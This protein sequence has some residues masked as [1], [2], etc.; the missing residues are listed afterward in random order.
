MRYS[1]KLLGTG[2]QMSKTILIVSPTYSDGQG[3]IER[4]VAGHIH[5]LSKHKRYTIFVV[6]F[7]GVFRI[8]DGAK[9]IVKRYQRRN[10]YNAVLK[11]SRVGAIVIVHDPHLIKVFFPIWLVTFF[12]RGRHLSLFTH[13]LFFHSSNYQRLKKMA[14]VVIK[15]VSLLADSVFVAGFA[16]YDALKSLGHKRLRLLGNGFDDFPYHGRIKP[17]SEKLRFVV[18]G[19][20]SPNKNLSH[21]ITVFTDRL[22]PIFDYCELI[23]VA[24]SLRQETRDLVSACRDTVVIEAA[25]DAEVSILLASSD[26]L[27]SASSFEGFGRTVVEAGLRGTIPF[28]NKNAGHEFIATK[29]RNMFLVDWREEADLSE[30]ITQLVAVLRSDMY[31]GFCSDLR[32]QCECF[33]WPNIAQ[34]V[35]EILD[36]K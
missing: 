13:G 15:R 20:D 22:R 32:K 24:P 26:V 25:D 21:V 27:L 2:L 11:Y 5:E 29:V 36:F 28:V 14:F 3:G 19:R 16:D 31:G 8:R 9:E 35:D 30:S 10:F 18:L 1:S 23:I 34:Q 4:F 33:L 12:G 17:E 6:F 7:D